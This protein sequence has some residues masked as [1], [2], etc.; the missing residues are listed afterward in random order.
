MHYWSGSTRNIHFRFDLH[1]TVHESRTAS[2]YARIPRIVSSKVLL[3]ATT[4]VEG[5]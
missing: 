2:E 3:G 5:I 4:N 1:R